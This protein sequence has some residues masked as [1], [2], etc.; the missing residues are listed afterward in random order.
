MEKLPRRL[1]NIS[2]YVLKQQSILSIIHTRNMAYFIVPTRDGNVKGKL[3]K[4][5]TNFPYY[6][7]YKVPFAKPPTGNLR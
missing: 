6:A 3:T 2:S 7:F 1:K 4:T 5:K